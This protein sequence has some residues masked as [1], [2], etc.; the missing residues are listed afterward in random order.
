MYTTK[1]SFGSLNRPMQYLYNVCKIVALYLFLNLD[2]QIITKVRNEV[3]KKF[4]LKY[5]FWRE[6]LNSLL[7]RIQPNKKHNT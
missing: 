7:Y 5:F 3:K 1:D 2:M 4:I 6:V